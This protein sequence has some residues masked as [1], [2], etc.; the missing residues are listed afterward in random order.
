VKEERNYFLEFE[1]F[2]LF[3]RKNFPPPAELDF[4]KE[5]ATQAGR[6]ALLKVSVGHNN[7]N[8]MNALVVVHNI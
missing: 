3:C 5:D 4:V 2:E 7:M 6:G 1:C 8:D